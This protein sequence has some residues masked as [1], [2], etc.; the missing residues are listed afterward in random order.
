MMNRRSKPKNPGRQL[1]SAAML[2]YFSAFILLYLR[3]FEWQG[4]ALAAAVPAMIWLG[5]NV[6]PHMFP[7]DK[8]LLSL[9]NFLCA[10]GVLVL[11]DTNPS[12]AYQQ[13]IYYSVGLFAMVFCVWIVR[14]IR[15]WRIPAML[16]YVFSIILLALPLLIG[17][18]TYGAKNWIH[19][20]G[21]SM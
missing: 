8:L 11:Y 13:A 3:D 2:F 5:T 16:L 6:L 21:I 14:L 18:E 15:N 19:A 7:S 12:Y 1:C 4:L 9:T 20:G 10:L 17:K